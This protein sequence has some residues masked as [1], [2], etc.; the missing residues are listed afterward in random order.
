MTLTIRNR[1]ERENLGVDTLGNGFDLVA[2]VLVLYQLSVFVFQ[3][4]EYPR[5]LF[6]AVAWG[7]FFITAGIAQ[8]ARYR[9]GENV[10]T[11]IFW[12]V[13]GTWAIVVGLDVAGSGGAT[14]ALPTAAV[15]VGAG[16]LLFV[17]MQS[18]RLVIIA[19]T[20]LGVTL[21]VTYAVRGESDLLAIGP[22]VVTLALAVA[23]AVLGVGIVR[24]IRTVVQLERDLAQAQSTVSAPRFAVGLMASEELARLDLDAERLLDGVGS[25]RTPLPLNAHTASAAATLATELRLHLIQGRRETWLYHAVSESAF[26]GPAV[27]VTDPDGLAGLLAADQRDGLLTA[28][29]LLISDPVR[30]GQSQVQSLQLTMDRVDRAIGAESGGP[31]TIAVAIVTAGVPRNGVDPAAWQAIRKVG[32][33]VETFTGFAM[34]IEVECVVD[35]PVD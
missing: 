20:V 16:L 14:D 11:W 35:N 25:G 8:I 18:A 3:L 7:L 21:A 5:I 12:T 15:A 29:W 13:I 26:L 32:R 1:G 2:Y 30:Q 9:F 6:T 17:T 31:I 28:V 23:P 24:S 27:T 22:A 19:A 33:Y 34:R 4:D 10:P